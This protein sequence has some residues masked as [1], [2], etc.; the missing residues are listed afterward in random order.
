MLEE[1]NNKVL[2]VV[3]IALSIYRCTKT[4]ERDTERLHESRKTI[5]QVAVLALKISLAV[6]ENHQVYFL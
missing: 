2:I 5:L 3:A 1:S 4:S 6:S